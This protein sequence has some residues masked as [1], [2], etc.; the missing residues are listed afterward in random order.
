MR[1]NGQEAGMV[2]FASAAVGLLVLAGCMPQQDEVS[3]RAL[4]MDNCAVCHGDAG[5]GDGPA[6]AGLTPAPTDLSLLSRQNGG[7]YPLVSV[8]SQIDGYTRAGPDQTMP[9]F[10][11]LLDGPLVG[12][13][14]GD[15]VITPTP[16]PLFA[17][18]EYL[19]TLQQ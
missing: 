13:D 7:V 9:D 19:R 12:V 15:G 10:G 8:M 5:R 17:L 14:T 6:A 2:R 3:G 11:E 16:A 4:F 1:K 18:A